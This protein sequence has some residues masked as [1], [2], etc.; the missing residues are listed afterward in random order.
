MLRKVPLHALHAAFRAVLVVCHRT[1]VLT[2]RRHQIRM[3][4]CTAA[5]DS[6]GYFDVM[7]AD[8]VVPLYALH[9]RLVLLR[10][11]RLGSL[12]AIGPLREFV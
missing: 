6:K 8:G 4:A 7:A 5:L 11:A 2:A 3:L 12:P 9:G 10:I 1:L